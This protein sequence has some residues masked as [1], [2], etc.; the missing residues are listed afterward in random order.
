MK[1]R[2]SEMKE[3]GVISLWGKT[4]DSLLR[5][6]VFMNEIKRAGI[7]DPEAI[8]KPS[9]RND[10]AFLIT[11]VGS[12]SVAATVAGVALPGDWGFFS[13]YLIGGIA[14]AVLAIGSV[15][16]GLLQFFI[17]KFSQV[18]PVR[19]VVCVAASACRCT[20]L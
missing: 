1:A 19:Q 15:N 10:A 20:G 9:V 14:L 7:Q 3:A 8:A 2:L 11:V 13:S 12:T 5:R 6:N 4:E 16:P 17:G 18:F